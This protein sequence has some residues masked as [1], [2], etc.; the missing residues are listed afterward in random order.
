MLIVILIWYYVKHFLA[1]RNQIP[2]QRGMY[3]RLF[4][5]LTSEHP[6]LWS[7]FGPR[8]DV[9]PSGFIGKIKWALL[10]EWFNADRTV[11]RPAT[12]NGGVGG[13]SVR[14]EDNDLDMFTMVQRGLVRRW[15]RNIKPAKPDSSSIAELGNGSTTTTELV[16]LS[17]PLMNFHVNNVAPAASAMG[18]PGERSSNPISF[19]RS[20]MT[21]SAGGG[22]VGT[23][24]RRRSRSSGRSML[25]DEQAA[26]MVDENVLSD[27]DP[28]D[29]VA[30]LLKLP[31]WQM[32]KIWKRTSDR[33]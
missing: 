3:E 2:Y 5:E 13:S 1:T 27:E 18:V 33:W 30:D 15:L 9:V 26:I 7:R 22:G 20:G 29:D 31:D 11:G 6:N 4:R 23:G 8:E 25:P 32:P 14:G 21:G 19:E 10:N 16:P 12:I 28:F 17:P 24:S